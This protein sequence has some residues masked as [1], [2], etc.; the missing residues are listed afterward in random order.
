MTIS[1]QPRAIPSGSTMIT[2]RLLADKSIGNVSG[3]L[4][5]LWSEQWMNRSDAAGTPTRL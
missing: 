5:K 4:L 3:L 2:V 1:S